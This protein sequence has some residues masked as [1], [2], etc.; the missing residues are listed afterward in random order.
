METSNTDC[1][2]GYEGA[3]E[4][5]HPGQLGPSQSGHCHVEVALEWL[6][7]CQTVSAETPV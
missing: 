5:A 7:H 3:Q 2:G 6:V 4:L 1:L